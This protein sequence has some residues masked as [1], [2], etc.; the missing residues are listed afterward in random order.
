MSRQVPGIM[1]VVISCKFQMFLLDHEVYCLVIV[2]GLVRQTNILLKN[3][4]TF[5]A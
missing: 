1:N 4:V 2:Q 5:M 3:L